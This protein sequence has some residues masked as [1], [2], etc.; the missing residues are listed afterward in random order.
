M[1]VVAKNVRM[2][3]QDLGTPSASEDTGG[4]STDSAIS[5]G[6]C[7]IEC[8]ALM[9]PIMSSLHLASTVMKARFHKQYKQTALVQGPPHPHHRSAGP[10]SLLGCAAVFTVDTEV[11]VISGPCVRWGGEKALQRWEP[12]PGEEAVE[13]LE[14]TPYQPGWNQFEINREKFNVQSTWDEVCTHQIPCSS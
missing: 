8:T 7:G 11:E 3:A 10:R 6:R 1:Q 9:Y 13:G 4:L 5:R 12:A 2:G 14:S